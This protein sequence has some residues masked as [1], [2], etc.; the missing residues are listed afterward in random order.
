MLR[1][2]GEVEQQH[3]QKTTLF[4]LQPLQSPVFLNIVLFQ[5]RDA[6]AGADG[7]GEEREPNSTSP[8]LL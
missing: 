8:S 3:I 1:R 7:I 4:Q 5:E 2:F 6:L